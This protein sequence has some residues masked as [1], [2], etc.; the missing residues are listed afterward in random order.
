LRRPTGAEL[1]NCGFPFAQERH[2]QTRKETET[3]QMRELLALAAA[4]SGVPMNSILTMDCADIYEVTEV[5]RFFFKVKRLGKPSSPT[6]RP[7]D[8]AATAPSSSA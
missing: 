1:L 2:P 8:G 5:M 6:S 3:V 7:E 4:S